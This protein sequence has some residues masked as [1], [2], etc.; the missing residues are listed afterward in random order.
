[1]VAGRFD[2]SFIRMSINTSAIIFD[3]AD[4]AMHDMVSPNDSPSKGQ[5]D[6]LMPQAYAQDGQA[7]LEMLDQLTITGILRVTGA[8]SEDTEIRS[9]RFDLFYEVRNVITL[10]MR[11]QAQL[12]EVLAD[13]E[14][15]AVISIYQENLHCSISFPVTAR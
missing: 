13:D 3:R 11:F 15:K 9:I 6:S 10:H 4:L 2:G 12:L 8:R 14:Y 7:S 1:M 5:S